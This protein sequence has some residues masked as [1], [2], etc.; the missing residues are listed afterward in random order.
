MMTRRAMVCDLLGRVVAPGL[1]VQVL[2]AAGCSSSEPAG[3]N[4]FT[5]ESAAAL[6]AR[7]ER[8]HGGAGEPVNNKARKAAR[9][10]R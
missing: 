3:A 8:L 7:R 4:Q 6:K 10:P 5:T 2:A 9:R 1:F